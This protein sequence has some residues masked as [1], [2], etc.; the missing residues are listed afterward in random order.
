MKAPIKPIYLQE[1]RNES[2]TAAAR[3]LRTAKT[4]LPCNCRERARKKGIEHLLEASL[5]QDTTGNV[6]AA[7]V[8]LNGALLGALRLG[9]GSRAAEGAGKGRVLKADDADVVGTADGGRAGHA[10]GHLDLDGEVGGGDGRETAEADAR[11][12]L[13]HLGVLERGGISTARCAVDGGLEWTGTVLVDLV[14]GHGDGS[15][16]RAGWETGARARASS[17]RDTRLRGALCGLAAAGTLHGLAGLPVAS[18]L[19]AGGAR[20]GRATS[21]ERG[22][23]RGSIYRPAALGPAESAGPVGAELSLPDDGSI[24]F[25]TAGW[26]CAVTGSAVDDCMGSLV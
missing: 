6:A 13:R 22:D 16:I 4:P 18:L 5:A 2:L 7:E 20:S 15:V 11:N 3:E 1:R 23:G 12:V 17:S 25:G 24:S 26:G 14:E 10:S 8:V 21:H 9:E 19:G